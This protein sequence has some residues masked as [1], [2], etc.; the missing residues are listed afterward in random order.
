MPV[1]KLHGGG[2]RQRLGAEA[3]HDLRVVVYVVASFQV[4]RTGELLD[5]HDVGQ[6]G[7]AEPQAS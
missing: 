4:Q 6:V 3:V 1:R 7:F 5:V 2:G